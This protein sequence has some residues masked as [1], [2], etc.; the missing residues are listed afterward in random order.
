VWIAPLACSYSDIY[1]KTDSPSPFE[2]EDDVLFTVENLEDRSSD[3]RKVIDTGGIERLD[4]K[5]WLDHRDDIGVFYN[6]MYSLLGR[7]CQSCGLEYDRDA[8]RNYFPLTSE[9]KS[10]TSDGIEHTPNK[11]LQVERKWYSV[12]TGKWSREPRAVVKYLEYGRDS[13]WRHLAARFKFKQFGQKWVLQV[14][15]GYYITK[16]GEEVYFDDR[17]GP[18]TTKQKNTERNMAVLNHVLFFSDCLA[19]DAHQPRDDA[20]ITTHLNERPVLEIERM[21]MTTTVNFGIRSDL[22]R[23]P[24]S[25]KQL[26]VFGDESAHSSQ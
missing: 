16:D 23:I 11:H 6:L 15:P 10:L 13:F 22:G 4:V 25:G 19:R 17:I 2:V 9:L 24:D 5:P 21:P 18:L 8:K 12:R 7:H 20:L 14:E 26:N 1:A 3:L